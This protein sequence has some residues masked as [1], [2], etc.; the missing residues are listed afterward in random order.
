MF[1]SYTDFVSICTSG[2]HLNPAVTIA[3]LATARVSVVR[4][5]L[6]IIF[7][8]LGACTGSALVLAVRLSPQRRKDR[9]VPSVAVRVASM[10]N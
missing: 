1:A 6:Y 10:W 7:Q 2:G 3:F 5:L 8:C 9:L 4:A